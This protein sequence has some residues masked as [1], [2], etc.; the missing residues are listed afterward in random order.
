MAVS[1]DRSHDGSPLHDEIVRKVHEWLFTDPMADGHFSCARLLGVGPDA[2]K[3]DI[4]GAVDAR[5]LLLTEHLNGPDHDTARRIMR[6]VQSAGEKL[7]ENLNARPVTTQQST[8]HDAFSDLVPKTVLR[9]KEKTAPAGMLS[10]LKNN[11]LVTYGA[12]GVVAAAAA[13]F[14]VSKMHTSSPEQPTTP[15]K[16]TL[17]ENAP[18]LAKGS[19]PPPPSVPEKAVAAVPAPV[20]GKP[21]VPAPTPEAT[22]IPDLPTPP[23]AEEVP[24][25]NA[26]APTPTP[27]APT[28]TTPEQSSPTRRPAPTREELDTELLESPTLAQQTV[29]QLIEQ[30]QRSKDHIAQWTL[31]RIALKN[32]RSA[33]NLDD[34]MTVLAE[35]QKR[36]EVDDAVAQQSMAAVREVALQKGGDV[37]Q[38]MMGASSVIR[39]LCAH[40]NFAEAKKTALW[41]KD[42]VPKENT[43]GRSV[44][45]GLSRTVGQMEKAYKDQ[46]IEGHQ[47]T[48]E[49]N[50]HDP[51]ANRAVGM[52][53][54]FE[55]GDWSFT[56]ALRAANDS[57][58][59]TLAER[60]E[61]CEILPAE[62]LLQL[63]KDLLRARTPA[64]PGAVAMAVHCL[65]LAHTKSDNVLTTAL[66]KD[67][68][69]ELKKGNASVLPFFR[70]ALLR[71]PSATSTATA[72]VNLDVTDA[73]P[74]GTVDLMDGKNLAEL[75]KRGIIV[76]ERW[77]VVQ[78]AGKD[79]SKPA[80]AIL[81]G[82]SGYHSWVSSITFPLSEEGKKIVQSGQYTC[83]FAFRRTGDG[84]KEGGF[85][86]TTAFIIPLPNGQGLPVTWDRNMEQ[87]KP[88]AY[89]S[90]FDADFPTG[91]QINAN[92]SVNHSRPVVTENEEEEYACLVT[93]RSAP[94]GLL[95][96]A[97]IVGNHGRQ[98]LGAL[99]VATP[100]TLSGKSYFL[101]EGNKR[102]PAK[103]GAPWGACVGGGTLEL[104]GAHIIP[105]QVGERR[106]LLQI[107]P[108]PTK[109][110]RL[111]NAQVFRTR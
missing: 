71:P 106:S 9:R 90:H 25:P 4:Q 15:A 77:E 85:Q 10:R 80:R 59:R 61:R 14:G 86:G 101:G 8:S 78:E 92:A 79:K 3:Q 74:P 105:E 94:G 7:I 43:A 47:K 57:A 26:P 40:D 100:N 58:L 41:I 36:F 21:V 89:Q 18:E 73:L 35:L 96:N 38:V 99:S 17:P 103:Q 69:V 16:L 24:A 45:I 72:N 111:R 64:G 91:H 49:Q 29:E 12:A 66:I 110:S 5:L 65:E 44:Y 82:T 27:V 11:K 32:A 33:Y 56:F 93:V 2:S 98:L 51:A 28:S 50:P 76:R 19:V 42:R 34:V 62:E 104:T 22:V 97:K 75:F 67:L 95:I 109:P 20:S 48:L 70:G 31:L 63:A 23:K 84:R 1:A 107:I 53:R 13:V 83:R 37:E 60:V 39:T 55:Q 46:K 108:E 30:A 68:L 52:Y 81:K 54:C 102:L 88:G 6:L 87:K